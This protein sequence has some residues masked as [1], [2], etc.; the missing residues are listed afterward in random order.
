MELKEVIFQRR[1]IR[2]FKGD[3]VSAEKVQNLLE[4][5]RV[6]PSWAN[7]Q[8]WRFVLVSDPEK[9]KT[10][11]SALPDS[12]PG[13]NALLQAPLVVVL[14]ADPEASALHEGKQY[15]MLDAGLAMEHFILAAVEEGLGTCWQA[16]LSG[17][18]VRKAVGAPEK[19]VVVAV[20]PLGYPDQAPRPRPR[21]ELNKIAFK[22]VW[23]QSLI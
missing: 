18:V 6:A 11:A 16:L 5:A 21:H 3:P 19:M 22:E 12:N 9:K 8:C 13:K 7:R 1:S 10:I 14:L 20:T 23:G 4:A 15:Y 2:K 17:E